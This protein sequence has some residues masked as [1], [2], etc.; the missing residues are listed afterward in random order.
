MAV[1]SRLNELARVTRQAT[2]QAAKSDQPPYIT[3]TAVQ[4]KQ[5][6]DHLVE[7]VQNESPPP[8]AACKVGCNACCHGPILASLPE[9]LAAFEFVCERLTAEEQTAFLARVDSN[10]QTNDDYW[11]ERTLHTATPCAFLVGRRCRI[12]EVRPFSCR[13]RNSTNR[14][15]CK[16]VYLGGDVADIPT[17]RVQAST[18]SLASLESAA[19]REA[20]LTSGGLEFGPGV[21]S[22]IRKPEIISN[23]HG[24]C[25][26]LERYKLVSESNRSGQPTPQSVLTAY[27]HPTNRQAFELVR[28]GLAEQAYDKL[29]TMPPSPFQAMFSLSMPVEYRSA[30][31]IELWWQRWDQSLTQMEEH[32]DWATALFELMQIHN[33]FGLAYAGRDGR[34]YMERLLAVLGKGAER[35]LP[36]LVA[37]IERPRKPGKFRLGY[38]SPQIQSSN[39]SR[40][41]L[42]W[43]R[44][45]SPEI[46]TYVFHA[47]EKEDR[48]SV[49]FRRNADHYFHLPLLTHDVADIVRALDLDALIFTDVGMTGRSVQFATL[50]L[51]RKQFNAWGHP[52]TSGSPTMD[53][54]LSSE[55]MEPPDGQD[56]YTEQLVPL[57][58]SGLTYPRTKWLVSDRPAEAFGLRKKG[59]YFVCQM[60]SKLL[61]QDDHLLLELADRSPIPIV[62]LHNKLTK[63]PAALADRLDHP[64]IRFLPYQTM[65]D[66]L[67]LLQLAKASLDSPSW[68]GA[69]TTI[70]AL[71]LG[72]PVISMTGRY[73]RGRHNRAFLGLANVPGLIAESAEDYW[74]LALNDGRR[75]EI[76]SHL[77]VDALYDD[78]TPVRA[79]DELLLS[80]FEG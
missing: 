41:A 54:Y 25:P 52:I 76:M 64:N 11:C 18:A 73:M 12:Y 48:T 38:I 13:A 16:S 42:G 19:C 7:E 60:S 80:G 68:N 66:Y 47:G 17:N 57:P 56:F 15:L 50:R 24:H 44:N 1:E 72:T 2:L 6:A 8:R 28:D 29:Q 51:A 21:A 30:D 77:V 70:E 26:D 32:D 5:L 58:N 34:P 46:E 31:E 43:L 62:V 53:F 27:N 78:L 23:L 55:M 74:D 49:A 61:P 3:H 79:I 37:P 65:P 22:L 35:L 67:R 71:T 36:R 33:T 59:F 69:N 14:S 75:D 4:L 10:E 40:W 45:H 20:G 9:V 63:A 39:G